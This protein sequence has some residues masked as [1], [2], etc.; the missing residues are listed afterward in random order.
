M[1]QTT[2]GYRTFAALNKALEKVKDI[3]GNYVRIPPALG[4][5]EHKCICI[6]LSYD[7]TPLHISCPEATGVLLSVISK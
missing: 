6:I 1:F 2:V 7:F 3:N 4:C 5:A